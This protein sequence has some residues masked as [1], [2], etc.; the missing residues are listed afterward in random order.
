[1]TTA[2]AP[3]GFTHRTTPDPLMPAHLIDEWDGPSIDTED[4][5]VAAYWSPESGTL[6][7][8][9]G[10]SEDCTGFDLT[11]APARQLVADLTA[12]LGKLDS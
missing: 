11:P 1:M 3:A 2:A 10:Y 8:V 6:V 9:D 4:K 12:V 5:R 7:A